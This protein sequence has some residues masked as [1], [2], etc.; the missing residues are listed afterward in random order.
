MIAFQNVSKHFGTQQVLTSVSFQINPGER[1]GVVGPNGTGKS[2]V[3]D[4]ISGE[5]SPDGGI[6][7]I[8]P[9]SRLGYL[10]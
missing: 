10:H 4:L 5:T 2:T 3:L 7:S 8:P 9:K 1:I 6:V